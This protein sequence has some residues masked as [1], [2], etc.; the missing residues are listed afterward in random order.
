MPDTIREQII[1]AVATRLGPGTRRA[2]YIADYQQA[3]LTGVIDDEDA[4]DPK[5]FTQVSALMSLRVEQVDFY[6]TTDRSVKANQML[7]NIIAAV[8]STDRTLGGLADY[9]R[10][11]SGRTFYPDEQSQYVGVSVTFE[12]SYR[13][14]LG[15]PTTNSS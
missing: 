1:Q 15:D 11:F 7:G 10:Y 5:E 13:F 2:P 14:D 4:I 8:T 6:G 3:P 12:V 9:I